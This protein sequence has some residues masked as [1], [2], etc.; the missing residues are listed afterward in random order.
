MDYIKFHLES[1]RLRDIDPANDC[2]RYIA[3]RFELNMEQR[4]WLAFLYSTC[5]CA[6]TVFYMYN[7]FPDFENVNVARL[8]RWWKS[9]KGKLVFQSDRRKVK[10][11]DQFVP[12]YQGYAKLIGNKT[13]QEVFNNLRTP[14]ARYTYDEAFKFACKTHYVGRFTAFIWLEMVSYLT[15]FQC[16]PHVL[17]WV[18]AD[19]CRKGMLYAEGKD[20]ETKVDVHLLRWLDTRME[21]YQEKFRKLDHPSIYNIETTLCAYKKHVEG[22][23]YPGYYIDRQLE[24]IQEMEKKVTEGVCWKVLWQFRKETYKYL[25]HESDIIGG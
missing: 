24:E 2:L 18:D 22:R 11:F 17:D 5:Y 20:P 7:E 8:E 3:D 14:V 13:Q 21:N 10:N 19:V 12:S 9:N 1:S 23:R 4:Y 15:D 6:P 25:K 16:E